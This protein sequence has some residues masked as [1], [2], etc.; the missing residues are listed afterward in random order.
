MIHDEPLSTHGRVFTFQNKPKKPFTSFV[1][2]QYAK[3][4]LICTS[5]LPPLCTAIY[6][7]GILSSL[8][9]CIKY[10]HPTLRGTIPPSKAHSCCADGRK[11]ISTRFSCVSYHDAQNAFKILRVSFRSSPK[12][13]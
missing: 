10:L 9:F 1:R 6:H 11:L 12:R 7:T 13:S 4:P 5:L 2:T 3:R 8:V